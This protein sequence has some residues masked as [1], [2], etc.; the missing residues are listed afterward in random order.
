MSARAEKGVFGAVAA[1]VGKIDAALEASRGE[2]LGIFEPEGRML[3]PAE[4]KAEREKGGRPKGA[5]SFKTRQVAQF[6][7]SIGADP[8]IQSARWL[9]ISPEELAARLGCSRVEA[10]DRQQSIRDSLLPFVHAKLAPTDDKGN[11][12]PMIVF[13]MGGEAAQAAPDG[14][15]RPAWMRDLE[16]QGVDLKTIENQQLGG[17]ASEDDGSQAPER[18]EKP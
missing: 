8:L 1:T 2:Q 11:V 14:S 7:Q 17:E 5:K 16:A 6:L 15:V 12:A 13:Q 18:E 3:S 10:W 4:A 9:T